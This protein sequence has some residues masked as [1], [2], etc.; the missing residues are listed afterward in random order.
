MALE[1][2]GWQNDAINVFRNHLLEERKHTLIEATPGAGK[3]VFSSLCV[4]RT[5]KTYGS[6]WP[7]IIVPTT[8]LK[9]SFTRAY[10]ESGIELTTHLREDQNRPPADYDG[11]VITYAQLTNMVATLQRWVRNGHR[12]MFIFDEVH[13]ASSHNSWGASA[14]ECADVSDVVLSMTGTPFRGDGR[15]ISFVR[16][17]DDGVAIPDYSYGYRKAVTDRVCRPL[18][19]EHDD[20]V[21]EWREG[22]V[23]RSS[24]ASTCKDEEAGRVQAGV[25]SPESDWMTKVLT[26]AAT[27]LDEYRSFDPDAG[28][29][30]ICRPGSDEN[31]ERHLNQV[32]KTVERV[33]GY[34]PT[35]ITHDDRDADAKI[36]RFRDGFDRWIVS[37][38][39]VSEG[40]DIKRLRVLVVASMPGTELLFRQLVGR[41]VRWEDRGETEDA[42][43]Y[44]AKFPKLKEWAERIAEEAQAGLREQKGERE[45]EER[46]E[47]R[48]SSD[49]SMLN[50]DH[51]HGGG[52]AHHGGTYTNQ[53]IRLAEE[54]KRKNPALLMAPVDVIL[55]TLRVSGQLERAE[56]APTLSDDDRLPLHE[57]KLK[58]WKVVEKKRRQLANMLYG[59]EDGRPTGKDYA[60]TANWLFRQVGVKDKNDLLDNHSIDKIDEM[61]SLVEAQIRRVAAKE[62]AD[63]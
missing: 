10:N 5:W 13:H 47:S 51:M 3:T 48:E 19:F 44:I 26:K 61:A 27:K 16:Y 45:H 21:V 6:V 29:L 60:D 28:G 15:R 31:E 38:R 8:A 18:F 56:E 9:Q 34:K 14:E 20:A 36:Q 1:P 43:V 23:L 32:A 12:L 40:V 30:I 54:Y 57:R 2:R 50:V 25:F 49:F 42:T 7:V 33:T 53:Q 52:V 62:G 22:G 24:Q 46:P 4:D 39:K 11:A 63:A 17:N 58:R 35:V 41:V 59:S 55:E 37:V